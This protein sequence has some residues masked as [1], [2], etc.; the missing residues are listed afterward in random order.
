MRI[1][2]FSTEK[3]QPVH[4]AEVSVREEDGLERRMTPNLQLVPEGSSGFDKVTVA[5]FVNDTDAHWMAHFPR[6]YP[7][8][9]GFPAAG[10]GTST[11]LRNAKDGNGRHEVTNTRDDMR[12]FTRR[13][14]TTPPNR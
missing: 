3:T 10:V 7:L 1:E 12:S 13:S 9:A 2:R 6:C 11:V 5:E 8:A 4:V 14:Q